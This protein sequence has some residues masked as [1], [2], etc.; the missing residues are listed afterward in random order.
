MRIYLYSHLRCKGVNVGKNCN[1]LGR[2]QVLRKPGSQIILHNHVAIISSARFNPLVRQNTSLITFSPRA[3]IELAT[4]AGISGSHIACCE[5]V[6]IGEKTII[7]ADT[8]IFDWKAHD[9]TPE[10]GWVGRKGIHGAPIHIGAKCYI[11][12]RCTILKGVTIGDY[13][14]VSAGT[15]VNKD[16]PA[17]HLAS[18]NPMTITPLPERLGGPKPEI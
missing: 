5:R 14:V 4:G 1:L 3:V 10:N 6:Y 8:L 12:T 11:G 17:G 9:Y 16:I 13:C 7:G 15:I 18:G 2:I